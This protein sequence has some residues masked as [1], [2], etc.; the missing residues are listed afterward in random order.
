MDRTPFTPPMTM[1]ANPFFA[2][3]SG[4]VTQAFEIWSNWF[5]TVGQVGLVNIDLGNTP[6]PDLERRILEEVGSYGRQLGRISEA[7]EVLLDEAAEAGTLERS[8]L[9]D[10]Q[11]VA[12][13]DFREMMA[14]VK[15]EKAKG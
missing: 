9:T 8:K 13:H 5:R 6:N 1:A 14:K 11:I 3:L 10:E 7:L 2:P 15:A 12:L 4:N